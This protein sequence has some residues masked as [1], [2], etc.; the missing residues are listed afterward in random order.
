MVL[1]NEVLS[2][3]FLITDG[4]RQ[5]CPLSPLIFALV[6]EPLAEAIRMHPGIRE[7]DIVGSQHKIKL[8]ADDVILALSDTERSL[9]SSTGVLERFCSL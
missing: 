6:K 8:F 1:T 7:V 3:P 4:T 5:G 2:K 9:P